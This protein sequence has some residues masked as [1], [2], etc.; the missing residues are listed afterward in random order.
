MLFL[1][2][3]GFVETTKMKYCNI[4]FIDNGLMSL[5]R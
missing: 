4:F 5:K 2:R 1:M 3:C